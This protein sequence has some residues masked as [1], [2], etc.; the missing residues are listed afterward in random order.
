MNN[1]QFFKGI[2]LGMV[3]GAAIGMALAPR[4]K[5]M[6]SAAGKAIKAVG[7]V[8]ENIAENIGK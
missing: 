5:S 4:P 6:K 8:V 7:D 3:T 1:K 2:G